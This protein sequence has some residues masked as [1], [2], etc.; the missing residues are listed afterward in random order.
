MFD[1]ATNYV[2]FSL[3]IKEMSSVTIIK[4]TFDL[5]PTGALL[6]RNVLNTIPH[7]NQF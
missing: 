2:T 7:Q 5:L 1:T 6:G 4:T 3:E